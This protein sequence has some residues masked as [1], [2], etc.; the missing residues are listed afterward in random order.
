MIL[1]PCLLLLVALVSVSA[2]TTDSATRPYLWR[3]ESQPPSYLFGTIH[4]PDPRVASLL[5]GA[6]E[7][8]AQAEVL[9]TEI[10]IDP[11]TQAQAAG[12]ALLP[13]DT[14]LEAE[15]GPAL[16]LRVDRL[17]RGML[18]FELLHGGVVQRLRPWAAAAALPMLE[19]Q[20]LN[21]FTYPMDQWLWRQAGKRGKERGALET[22]QEQLAVFG[23]L[24][25]AEQIEFLELTV[26]F[27]EQSAAQ[28][29]DPID[30]LVA[31]YRSGD[32]TR[33]R[34]QF[35]AW[36]GADHPLAL[37]LYQRLLVE[38][39]VRMADRIVARLAEHG[40]RIHLF[41]VGA[42]HLAEDPEGI[43]ARL[44]ERGL[45]VIRVDAPGHARHPETTRERLLGSP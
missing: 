28:G 35:F 39:N 8:F 44:R 45:E 25:A 12:A 22:A 34:E 7:A 3:I 2:A 33:F 31:L 11:A 38:R 42:A 37:K 30:D 24:S 19:A 6:L 5:P 43:Q 1:R 16:F 26:A 13:A 29:I 4:L 23:G 18:P 41:A 17:L 27:F 14:T 36:T 32:A 20:L 10:P 15:I 21:P 9:F 40:D